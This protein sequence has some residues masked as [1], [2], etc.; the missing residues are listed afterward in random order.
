MPNSSAAIASDKGRTPK[1]RR[2]AEVDADDRETVAESR[3]RDDFA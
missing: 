2:T 3:L 1:P